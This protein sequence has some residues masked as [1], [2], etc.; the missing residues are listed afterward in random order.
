[1]ATH[2]TVTA[3]FLD[4][5][6][7]LAREIEDIDRHLGNATFRATNVGRAKMLEI[8]E[9]TTSATGEARAARGG[10]AGRIDTGNMIDAVKHDVHH[11]GSTP[12]SRVHI[13]EWG[14]L[15]DF[16]GYFGLQDQWDELPAGAMNALQGSYI[17]AREALLEELRDI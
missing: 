10:H 12:A 3:A 17:A 15:E 11:I 14:W 1:M 9:S 16:E 4:I 5:E 8:I 2:K 6:K 7:F 13:G